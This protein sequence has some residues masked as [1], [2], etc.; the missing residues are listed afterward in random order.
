MTPL[1]I[2][3]AKGGKP[4]DVQLQLD[5]YRGEKR[6]IGTDVNRELSFALVKDAPAPAAT[7]AP[8]RRKKAAAKPEDE[9]LKLLPPEL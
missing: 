1:T 8:A 7:P 9:N 4:L 6:T 3:T 2:K 5:G